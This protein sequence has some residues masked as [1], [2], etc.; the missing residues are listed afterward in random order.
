MAYKNGEKEWH[1]QYRLRNHE[2]ILAYM[3]EYNN[4]P[5]VQERTRKYNLNPDVIK[6]RKAYEKEYKS[7]PKTKKLACIRMKKM[8]DIPTKHLSIL[9]SKR[10][11][12]V[13]VRNRVNKNGRHWEDVLGFTAQELK[14]HLEKQ[15]TKEMNW[16][17]YGSYWHIDHKTPVAFASTEREV[18]NLFQL[19]NLQ[20]LE[21]KENCKKGKR[22]IAN[23]FGLGESL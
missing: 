13:M 22:V 5:E 21:A 23:L 17:N 1:I 11:Q 14:E 4:R 8:K 16:G 20:P 19:D 15:F 7:R 9:I 18:I 10:L 2:K 6:K 3:K 12:K